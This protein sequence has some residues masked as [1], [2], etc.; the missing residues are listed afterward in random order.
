MA[1]LDLESRDS[2]DDRISK[3]E[4]MMEDKDSRIA[5]LEAAMEEKNALIQ[6]LME[7]DNDNTTQEVR[8]QPFAI[9]CG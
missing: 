8:N 7:Q 1:G 9:Q 5:A 4:R 3:I 6:T 2:L